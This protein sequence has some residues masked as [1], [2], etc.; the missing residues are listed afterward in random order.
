MGRRDNPSDFSHLFLTFLGLP[1]DTDEIP[2]CGADLPADWSAYGRPPCP[3]C[4]AEAQ[5]RGLALG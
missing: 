1:P 5:R 3:D 2:L 4:W